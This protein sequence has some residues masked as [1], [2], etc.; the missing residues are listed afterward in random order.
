MRWRVK[1]SKLS[2]KI[3]TPS[4]KSHTIRALLIATLATGRSVIKDAL[5]SGDGES[6]LNAAKSLGAKCKLENDELVIDGVG[7]N[8]DLGD[9]KIFMGNSGTGTRLFTSA[10]ALGTKKRTFDGDES[11]RTRPMKPL[12]EALKTLGADYSLKS[13]K[14]D[15]PYTISGPLTGGS[16]V[17]DGL[18]SQYLSS[19]LLT[20]PIIK[21]DTI[22]DVV[23]LHE[24]PYIK[25]TL[26]WLDR[27][28]IKYEARDDLSSFH[29][30]G[31]QSYP[32]INSR[33]PG[34]F[35][36]AT[37]AAVAASLTKCELTVDNIDFS[38]PQGDKE[39]FTLLERVGAKV[40][41]NKNS[42]F[43]D[44]SK[45]LKGTILDLNKMPDAL[46][47]FAVLATAA[48][49]ETKIVNTQQARI[50]ETDRISVMCDELTKMGADIQ[51][52]P[53][54]LVIQKSN[55]KGAVVN[56]HDDHRVVMAL[57]L[58]G[59]VAS[60]ETIIETAEAASVTYESFLRD[61]KNIGADIEI[62]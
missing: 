6:A 13:E 58:A 17:V 29:I 33:I 41:R 51:E 8:Y 5:L 16:V 43:V 1:P 7:E 3:I 55:L 42:A 21:N 32:T 30:V 38:D 50:K 18:T 46:P 14:L 31:N 62:V 39:I 24:K 11:L 57:A 48:E 56:G 45:E 53:D 4:S 36:S 15:L 9:S 54:G 12:L 28:G 19:L 61:F 52:R 27:M 44:G 40:V 37:F 35:S 25:I 10:A 26:W 59:M 2:G 23:N 20:S 49:G 47:A 22:I 60:G 34:D